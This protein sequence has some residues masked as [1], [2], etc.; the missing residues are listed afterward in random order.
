MKPCITNLRTEA[1]IQRFVDFCNVVDS[2]ISRRAALA[3]KQDPSQLK[4]LHPNPE[5]YSCVESFAKDWQVY[6]FLRKYAELPGFTKKMQDE[7]AFT[8]WSA[9]E[10]RCFHTNRRIDDLLSGSCEHL[11]TPLTGHPGEATVG[12]A[13]II[14]MAQA[15]IESVLGPFNF[16]KVTAECRWSSGATVDLPR[17]TQMSKK[18]T[19]RITVTKRAFPHLRKVMSRDPAWL[20]A[21]TGRDTYNY[22]SPLEMN[23]DFVEYNRHL[24]V[25]KTAFT[26][27][28]I[29]AEPTGNSFLQQG[30]GRFIRARLKRFGVDL[31]D[32][33]WNQYLA[34]VAYRLG[35]STIDLE[36]ASDSVSRQLVKL[37][38]P[39]RWFDYLMDLRTTHSKVSHGG[40]ARRIRLE[41]FS[42]MGNAFTFELESLIFWALASAV[43]EAYPEKGGSVGV[44]G[45]DIVVKRDL[46]QPLVDVLNWCGFKVNSAKSFRDGNF[47][48]S[49][50]GNYFMGFDVT[51][52][53]QQSLVSDLSEVISFHNRTLRWS[54]R[55]F[56]TPFAPV[57][58]AIVK[59]LH[60]GVHTLPMNAPDDRGFLTPSRELGR[61]DPNHGY[62]CRV[63]QFVPDREIQYKQRAYY[64][65]KLRRKRLYS[66]TD[67]QG[68]PYWTDA[69]AGKTVSMVTWVQNWPK[70]QV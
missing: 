20:S 21:I 44:Y 17:G 68:Q 11:G 67:R 9:G 27:R 70:K 46:Y 54:M 45:D 13:T 22:A 41:K 66:N 53:H 26:G 3:V 40:P 16:K 52:F 61:F 23:F 5:E 29:A 56:G 39:Q 4:K 33:S 62:E 32:Q 28:C 19:E 37:L 15:K 58:K 36:G 42:S 63:L 34:Q 60:D 38:L 55:I 1:V 24:I 6:S 51:G 65:Y 57:A 12:L 48:E 30:T 2:S 8:S 31:D 25:A 50:G 69:K 64:A 10:L 7:A 35:Y 49:C 18:M 14:S 43:N 47:F 59:G